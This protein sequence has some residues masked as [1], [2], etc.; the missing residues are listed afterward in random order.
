[1][2]CSL[3]KSWATFSAV[4]CQPPWREFDGECFLVRLSTVNWAWARQICQSL[5]AGADLAEITSPA[6]QYFLNGACQSKC[7]LN[8]KQFSCLFRAFG[9]KKYLFTQ[10]GLL[11]DKEIYGGFWIGLNSLE[12][13]QTYQWAKN[14]DKPVSTCTYTDKFSSRW[15]R[16]A[17]NHCN[18]FFFTR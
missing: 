15:N 12:Q 16:L 2:H 4:S 7:L 8:G 10:T 5:Q 13:W 1:M 18:C 11:S 6:T 9:W 3:K 17:H 14:K